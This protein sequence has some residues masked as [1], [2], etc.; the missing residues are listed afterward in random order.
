MTVLAKTD[1]RVVYTAVVEMTGMA[2]FFGYVFTGVGAKTIVT[3]EVEAII[4]NG[5]GIFYSFIV[6]GTGG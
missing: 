1:V 5:G 3:F 4:V 6:E 2:G